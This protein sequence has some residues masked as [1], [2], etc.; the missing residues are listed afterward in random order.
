M[1]QEQ[2]KKSKG[3]TAHDLAESYRSKRKGP[4]P[5]PSTVLSLH[6]IVNG[7]A[8]LERRKPFTGLRRS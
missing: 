7:P 5:L 8:D 4:R 6:E 1:T 3:K 2:Q